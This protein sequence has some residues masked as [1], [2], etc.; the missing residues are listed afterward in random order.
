MSVPESVR[1]A[2]QRAGLRGFGTSCE[3]PAGPLLAVLA[4]AVPPGGRVPE[5]GAGT[6]TAW[7]AG[8]TPR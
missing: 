7:P 2:Q 4:A 3:D 8:M 5:L 6:G 1:Q